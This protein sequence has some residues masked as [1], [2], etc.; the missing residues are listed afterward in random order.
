MFKTDRDVLREDIA[1]IPEIIQELPELVEQARVYLKKS[2]LLVSF[3]N[4]TTKRSFHRVIGDRSKFRYTI[5]RD[6]EDDREEIEDFVTQLIQ[7]YK[8]YLVQHVRTHTN[9]RTRK[10]RK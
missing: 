3:F 2:E 6:M 7:L 5:S 1:M 9:A 10:I 4:K 8:D